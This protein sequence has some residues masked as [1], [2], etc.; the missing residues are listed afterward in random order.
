M[1]VTDSDR[2]DGTSG[3]GLDKLTSK[4]T[5]FISDAKNVK[6]SQFVMSV[7]AL[8]HL[9]TDLAYWTWVELFPKLWRVLSETQRAVSVVYWCWLVAVLPLLRNN[10]QPCLPWLFG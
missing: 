9:D 4:L 10:H 3:V 5:G 2:A 1:E 6:T 7:S 8:C